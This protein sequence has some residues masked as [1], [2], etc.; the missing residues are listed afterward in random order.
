MR[1]LLAVIVALAGCLPSSRQRQHTEALT[2]G[3]SL[4]RQLAAT[5]P[6]DSLTLAWVADAQPA[7][8]LPTTLLWLPGSLAG[9][10]GGALVVAD[11]RASTLHRF[12]ADGRHAGVVASLT[13]RSFPYLAGHRGDTLVVLSRGTDHLEF[14]VGGQAVRSA[15]LLEGTT[16]ALATDAAVYVKTTGDAPALFRLGA[17]RR[18]DERWRLVG[19]AW[20][21]RGFLRAWGDSLL[22]LSGYRPV[23]DVLAPGVSAGAVLDTL[24][25]VGFDSPQLM[26]S[27]QFMLGEEEEPP[28]MTPAAVAVGDRLFVLNLRVDVVRVDVYG[29]DGRIERALVGP[30]PEEGLRGFPVDLAVRQEGND[31]ALAVLFQNPGGAFSRPGGRLTLYRWQ[32][33]PDAL[34]AAP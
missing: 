19:P 34:T 16:A 18:Q 6:I 11:T 24:A 22:S 7:L 29:R 20:R 2:P 26:H 17:D 9:G 25:L 4:S 15:P 27:H 30:W 33:A 31:Y 32:P 10:L 3:D 13:D 14:L 23:V 21:H 5:I 12:T 1:V 8:G 28:L